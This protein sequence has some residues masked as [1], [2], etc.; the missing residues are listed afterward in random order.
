MYSPRAARMPV[1]NA[2]P[3]PRYD[4]LT[5]RAPARAA[6]NSEPSFDPLSQTITSPE[7][8]AATSRAPASCTQ[9]LTPEFS[10]KQ[11]KTMLTSQVAWF[12]QVASIAGGKGLASTLPG[13]AITEGKYSQRIDITKVATR[14]RTDCRSALQN[15]SSIEQRQR[16]A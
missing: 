14:T 3:Y 7:I 9:S 16:R 4:S 13:L 6:A 8:P 15:I 11:G 2:E 5:T 12:S 1:R 10:F